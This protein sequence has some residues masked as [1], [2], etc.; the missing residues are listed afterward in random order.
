MVKID[1]CRRS[2][3]DVMYDATYPVRPSDIKGIEHRI[4]NPVQYV[5]LQKKCFDNVTVSIILDSGT[6]VLLLA[7]KTV[8]VL[9]FRRAMHSYFSI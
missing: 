5:P 6:P 8:V 3:D 7:G 4:M 1:N 2:E 9:E